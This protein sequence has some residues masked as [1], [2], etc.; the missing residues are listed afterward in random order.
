M[1]VTIARSRGP[2]ASSAARPS[3]ASAR[4]GGADGRRLGAGPGGGAAGD[5]LRGACR[6]RRPTGRGLGPDAGCTAPLSR[7]AD[8]PGPGP[9]A[10]GRGGRVRSAP[11]R[12]RCSGP[13]GGSELD[14]AELSPRSRRHQIV[15]KRIVFCSRSHADRMTGEEDIR[16][17]P[18]SKNPRSLPSSW[19]SSKRRS[20]RLMKG[21]PRSRGHAAGRRG[22][23][24]GPRGTQ[25]SAG[26]DEDRRR[27]RPGVPRRA[28]RYVLD[29]CVALKWVLPEPDTP[30]AVRIRTEFLRGDLELI[31]PDIFPVEVAHGVARAERRGVIRPP[32]G[33]APAPQHP[34]SRA[35]SPSLPAATAA[36]LRPGFPGPHRRVGLPIRGVGRAGGLRCSTADDRLAG[37]QPAHP[38]IVL[39]DSI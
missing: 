10:V 35:G 32:I 5:R 30:T 11:D 19:R 33:A 1:G 12:R 27:S 37:A 20:D 14:P 17:R 24:R 18:S 9:A 6:V 21:V 8:S 2:T 38:F 22:D 25:E 3:R 13:P 7:S 23:G 29:S 4:P 39:L 15:G 36:S 28:M 34:E 31:A 16:C 26:R